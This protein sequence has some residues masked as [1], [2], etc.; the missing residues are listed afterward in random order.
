MTTTGRQD[1]WN[2]TPRPNNLHAKTLIITGAASG[3]GR[4]LALATSR[5]GA[6]VILTDKTI[7]GLENIYDEIIAQKAPAEPAIYPID[8]SGATRDD[9]QAMAETLATEF[10]SVDGL[11]NNAGWLGA[12]VPFQHYDMKL[13]QEV[14]MIN[15]HAPF[16]L[17]QAVLPLLEKSSDPSVV[18]STHAHDVAYAGAFGIAKAG[19]ESMLNI[20]ADEYDTETPIRFNGV[21]A[22]IVDTQMRRLNFPGEDWSKHPQPESVIAPYLYFLGP[23]SKGVSGMNCRR[24]SSG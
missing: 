10:G 20:L 11:V 22:G 18:F 7:S 9:Y 8:M 14:M 1:P 15:L 5:L 24:T 12:Y 4:A 16:M 2:Y 21:D 19:L 13:Y 3:I 17:T 23:D 6:T